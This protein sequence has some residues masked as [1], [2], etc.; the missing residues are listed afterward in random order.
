MIYY[1]QNYINLLLTLINDE[2]Y[3]ESVQT[4]VK[5]VYNIKRMKALVILMK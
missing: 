4:M 2:S 1:F 3:S 5:Q